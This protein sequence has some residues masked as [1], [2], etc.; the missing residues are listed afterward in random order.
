MKEPNTKV[1]RNAA[2]MLVARTMTNWGGPGLVYPC[3]QFGSLTLALSTEI[4][5]SSPSMAP[6]DGSVLALSGEFPT[7]CC[8]HKP[9]KN[10]KKAAREEMRRA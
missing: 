7:R 10:D 5:P 3:C 6:S 2:A 1:V 4:V 8:V 9:R